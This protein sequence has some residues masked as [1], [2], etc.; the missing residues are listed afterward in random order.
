MFVFS[1]VVGRLYSSLVARE[2]C[3]VYPCLSEAWN[4]A[5]SCRLTEDGWRGVFEKITFF[6]FFF[7]EFEVGCA[8]CTGQKKL[9]PKG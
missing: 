3:C 9:C 6:F 8:V 7:A 2:H 5:R 4:G 1:D